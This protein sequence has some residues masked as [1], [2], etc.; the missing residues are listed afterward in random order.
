MGKPLAGFHDLDN[1]AKEIANMVLKF[2]GE[3]A[4]RIKSAF[5]IFRIF[6]AANRGPDTQIVE[7]HPT[8]HTTQRT[9][10]WP[11]C[12]F[13]KAALLGT[14]CVDATTPQ[15]GRRIFRRRKGNVV[16]AVG[17][18]MPVGRPRRGERPL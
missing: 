9:I 18:M 8:Q 1:P 3:G 6:E 5:P 16:G 11:Q 17:P 2:Q 4:S 7:T 10:R 15:M 12:F 14:F 13:N